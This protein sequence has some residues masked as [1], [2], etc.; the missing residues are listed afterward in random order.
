VQPVHAQT[1]GFDFQMVCQANRAVELAA[2]PG[3][4]LQPRLSR[5]LEPNEE[6]LQ[7]R[8]PLTYLWVAP[9]VP[10][11]LVRNGEQTGTATPSQNDRPPSM[12]PRGEKDRFVRTNRQVLCHTNIMGPLV[13]IGPLRSLTIGPLVAGSS[14]W[15][16]ER[17]ALGGRTLADIE[18]ATFPPGAGT[19]GAHSG[20]SADL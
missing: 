9:N 10:C 4:R 16:V 6:R 12:A 2:Q 5:N 19:S 11:Q 13:E 20:L 17:Q 1:L 8:R 15:G 3:D 14:R 18:P 7:S